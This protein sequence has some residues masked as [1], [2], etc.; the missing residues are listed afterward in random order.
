MLV[1]TLAEFGS[2]DP[3]VAHRTRAQIEHVR[4]MLRHALEHAMEEGDIPAWSNPDDLA[5]VLVEAASRGGGCLRGGP[6]GSE[7]AG[8]RC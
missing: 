4:D 7:P 8:V 3:E 2:T 5:L 6:T 1:T